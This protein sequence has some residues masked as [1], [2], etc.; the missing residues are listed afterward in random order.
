MDAVNPIDKFNTAKQVQHRLRKDPNDIE[1]LL[2]LAVMPETL[3]EPDLNQK[4]K[5]LHRV[6]ALEP[7]NRQARQILFEMDRAAIGGDVSRLS[8][9]VILTPQP[10]IGSSET[11][12]KL[13]YSIVYQIL[14]YAFL[15]FSILLL[16][17]AAGE[18]EGFGVFAVPFLLLLIPV[19]FISAI[20]EISDSGLSLSRL[21]GVY[22]REMEWKEIEQ[23]WPAP[24]GTGMRLTGTDGRSLTISSQMNEY[25]SVVEIL[26]N[27]RSDLFEVT[28]EQIFQKGFLAKYGRFFF[29]VPATPLALGG[30][31]VPPFLG[32]ILITVVVF[33]LWR[34]ALQAVFL[35][36]VDE[37]R[38]FVSSFF[39]KR[40]FAAQQ[41]QNME[42]VTVRNRRGVSKSL[43]RVELKDGSWFTASGFAEGNKILYGSLK[44]WWNVYQNR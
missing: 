40:T 10:L 4:R 8:A 5:V 20:L 15:A 14:V 13:R 17:M 44:N 1:A 19:W 24:M 6:L 27:A 42:M 3:K 11:P 41:I 34:S 29:L 7:A 32:G 9:A 36:R 23:I 2:Q 30:I 39:K 22:R 18:W 35:I 28:S 26:R 31:L 21:F 16:F 12:L 33:F 37:N 38:L 25:S 43:V